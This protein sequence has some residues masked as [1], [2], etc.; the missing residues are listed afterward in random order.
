MPWQLA[1]NNNLKTFFEPTCREEDKNELRIGLDFAMA[2]LDQGKHVWWIGRVIRFYR[3]R[4][5]SKVLLHEPVPLD[6]LPTDVLVSASWYGATDKTRRTFKHD[7][8]T[9][10]AL[11]P[12]W[13]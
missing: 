11:P 1:P 8:V 5:R 12:L 4:A 3:K 7:A 6:E 2:F 10:P 9:D 13:S